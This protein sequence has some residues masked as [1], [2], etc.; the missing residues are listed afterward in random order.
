M[1]TKR[2]VRIFYSL[3]ILSLFEVFLWASPICTVQ[4]G[5]REYFARETNNFCNTDGDFHTGIVSGINFSLVDLAAK[6][7]AK[8]S[9]LS[10]ARHL[11]SQEHLTTHDTS[12]DL[13]GQCHSCVPGLGNVESESE[14]DAPANAAGHLIV[15]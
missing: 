9:Q 1:P 13:L 14:S 4:A 5:A 6:V 15:A 12:A 3:L 2:S 8:A 11:N 7:E 10:L